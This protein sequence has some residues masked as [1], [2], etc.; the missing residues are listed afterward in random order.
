MQPMNK[1]RAVGG[2]E[3]VGSRKEA[4]GVVL[5]A[6]GHGHALAAF[7]Y[8][9]ERAVVRIGKGKLKVEWWGK[10]GVV[11]WA[12]RVVG[13]VRAVRTRGGVGMHWQPLNTLI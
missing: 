13:V 1:E 11:L 5:W 4:I 10:Q 2:K 3:A 7:K 6:G 8:S 12:V 9:L